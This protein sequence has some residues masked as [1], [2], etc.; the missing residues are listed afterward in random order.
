MKDSTRKTEMLSHESLAHSDGE[1]ASDANYSKSKTPLILA[2]LKIK[3]EESY[4]KIKRTITKNF[5]Y[6]EIYETRSEGE[7]ERDDE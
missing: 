7:I 2:E 6:L 1:A 5:G 4:E 3:S